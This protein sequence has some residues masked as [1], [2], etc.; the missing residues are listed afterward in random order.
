MYLGHLSHLS[1]ILSRSSEFDP[2]YKITGSDLRRFYMKSC[3]LIMESGP[4]QYNDSE[5]SMLGSDDGR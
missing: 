1:H 5:L 3:A 2:V 4:D